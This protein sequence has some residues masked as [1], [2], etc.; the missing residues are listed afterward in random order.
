MPTI[1][2][3]KNAQQDEVMPEIQLTPEQ[4]KIIDTYPEDQWS[5]ALMETGLRDFTIMIDHTP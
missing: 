3:F 4:Q 2:V 1:Q 5:L